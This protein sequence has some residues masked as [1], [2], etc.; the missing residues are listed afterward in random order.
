MDFRMAK[1]VWALCDE[2]LTEHVSMIQEEDAKLWIFEVMN[3]VSRPEFISILVTIWAI[4]YA[5]RK[6]IF[7]VDGIVDPTV[8]ECIACREL[9]ICT[10]RD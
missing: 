8:L 9:V 4:W 1:S 3:T 7:T 5:R 6:A 10:S 2:Q